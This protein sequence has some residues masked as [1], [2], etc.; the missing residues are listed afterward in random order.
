MILPRNGRTVVIDDNFEIHAFPLLKALYKNGFSSMYFS[1]ERTELPGNPMDD[2]RV[3]FLDM[4]LIRPA[5]DNTKAAFTAKT[6]S[7]IIDLSANTFY[8]IIIWATHLELINYFWRYVDENPERNCNFVTIKLDKA[9]CAAN[10]FD[11][12]FIESEINSK[13]Q[14]NKGYLFLANWENV[15]NKS[16]NDSICELLSLLEDEKDIDQKLLRIIKNLAIA[17]EGD[18]VNNTSGQIVKNAMLAFNSIYKDSLERN[19]IDVSDDGFDFNGVGEIQNKKIKAAI[20]SKLLLCNNSLNP[21]PGNIYLETNNELHKNICFD[22]VDKERYLE[23]VVANSQL[24]SCEVSPFCDYA[25]KKW[26]VGRLVFGLFIDDGY[27][28]RIKKADCL[29]KT[30]LLKYDDKVG[31]FV[32]DMRRAESKKLGKWKKKIIFSMRY[33]LVVDLQHKIGGHCSRPGMISL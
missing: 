20:N 28:K 7:K 24:I 12:S 14:S 1:G 18:H 3:I 9:L 29:Y 23:E 2:V 11:I 19:T 22:L 8:F 17:Y 6:L 30:P 21:K 26:R 5:D 33:D 25:Q 15:I 13:L 31:F 4:E 27:F 32:F 16:A 10:N